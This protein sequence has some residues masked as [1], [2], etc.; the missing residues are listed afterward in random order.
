MLSTYKDWSLVTRSDKTRHWGSLLTK[1]N[2]ECIPCI[3][4]VRSREIIMKYDNTWTA[5]NTMIKLMKEYV[6]LLVSGETNVTVIATKL[7]RKAKQLIGDPDPYCELKHEANR[8][9]LELYHKLKEY[10]QQLALRERLRLAVRASLI[11]NSLDLGVSGY[12]PPSTRELLKLVDSIE[13]VGEGYIGLL[14]DV[15]DKLVVYLLDNAG[16]A[17]LDRLLADELR[18][19]G[20]YV[21]GIVKSGSFQNDV[22]EDNIDELG[23]EESFDEVIGTGSDASSIFFDEINNETR[24]ILEKADLII[25]KGMAHYEYL[26]DYETEDK[27][28]KTILY[29]LKAKC[30]PIA[31]SL[32]VEKGSYVLKKTK[33]RLPWK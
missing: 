29:M 18:A 10:M 30:N 8:N 9:G 31:R 23:L 1:L 33:I 2:V 17:A 28:G 22:T 11:G 25:S 20:A 16:E 13:I 24:Q 21:I 19:L 32:G 3:L 14:E 15:K 7:F 27:E 12:E 6:E 26:S 4:D 5:V